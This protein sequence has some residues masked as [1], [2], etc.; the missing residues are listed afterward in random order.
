MKLAI[1]FPRLRLSAAVAISTL[2]NLNMYMYVR[3]S[4]VAAGCS[5]GSRLVN[6]QIQAIIS[7]VMIYDLEISIQVAF[8]GS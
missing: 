3:T 1:M 6:H 8:Y 7:C 2:I 5:G 4:A